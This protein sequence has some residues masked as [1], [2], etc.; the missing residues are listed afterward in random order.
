MYPV[1]LIKALMISS[2]QTRDASHNR[3][4]II[5]M[6]HCLRN[7][8]VCVLRKLYFCMCALHLYYVKIIINCQFE[9]EK[10]IKFGGGSMEVVGEREGTSGVIIF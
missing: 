5:F 7:T 6:L 9:R 4:Q 10:V 3:V 1:L 2:N 8:D